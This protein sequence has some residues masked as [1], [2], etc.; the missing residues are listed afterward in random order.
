MNK[1]LRSLSK[2][3]DSNKLYLN[4]TKT[5]VL[6]FKRKGRV[7][8]TDLKLKLCGKK[9]FTSKSVKYLGVILDERLQWNFHI[10][11][12]FLK[13]NEANTML[14]KTRH[15]VNKTSLRSIYYAIFQS[16]LSYVCTAWGQNTKYTEL[17]LTKESYGH[18][19]FL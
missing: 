1:D 16:H 4:I 6:I 19:F 10:N 11:Q 2:W 18:Y 5:E 8:D 9:L 7:F 15:Y 13:F 17:A 14:C 12:F 3:L